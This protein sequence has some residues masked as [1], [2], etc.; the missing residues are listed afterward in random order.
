MKNVA[1]LRASFEF[2]AHKANN[3]FAFSSPFLYEYK[4]LKVEKIGNNIFFHQNT[5]NKK[6]S[7]KNLVN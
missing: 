6:T 1:I 3:A 5:I 4:K 2:I 7:S